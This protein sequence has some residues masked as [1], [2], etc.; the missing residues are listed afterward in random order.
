VLDVAIVGGGPVGSAVAVLAAGSGLSIAIFEAR[1]KPSGDRRILALSQASRERLEEARAWPAQDAT[2][3]ASIHISQRGGPGRT[4][5]TAAEQGLPAL[6]YTV[7]YGALEDALGRRL[8]ELGVELRR[9]AACEAISLAPDAATLRLSSGEEASARLLVIADGGASAAKIPGIAFA[10]K[11]YGQQAIVGPVRTD[12]PHGGRAYERF[13]PQGPLALLPVRE[14][15]ALVWT[16]APERAAELLALPETEFLERLQEA[17]GDRA[18]R[19]TAIESR[20]AF[21]LRLRSVNTPVALRTAIVGNAA[22]ALHPVAGQGLNLGLRDAAALADRLRASPE[23]AGSREMLDAYREARRRDATRG[24][25]FT[26]FLVSIFSEA[27][28]I[29]TWGRG[30]ALA[31]FDLVPPARRL[32][33]ERM[34]HGAPT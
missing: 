1:E 21:P 8:A 11:D 26:D 19:F 2:P 22:Q 20:G 6:G 32:L 34:I 27:G 17:F 3:I 18:G 4:L 13:T 29:P 14:R 30:L 9:G 16:A 33:A 25:A 12:R 28:R 5:L 15:Y 23:S 7:P 31:A 10:E 24:I